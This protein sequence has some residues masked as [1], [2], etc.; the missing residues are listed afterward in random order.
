M[1]NTYRVVLSIAFALL[2]CFKTVAQQ[3]PD[4]Y[5][6]YQSPDFESPDGG[7]ALELDDGCIL[8]SVFEYDFEWA[9]YEDER[10]AAAKI[11]KLSPAGILLG[12]L[13][14]GYEGRRST[15]AGIYRDP[16]DEN[17]CVA[18]GKIH[19]NTMH[20][21]LPLIVKFDHDLNIVNQKEIELP[22]EYRCFFYRSRSVMDSQGDIVYL[23]IPYQWN[24][25]NPIFRHRTYMR[26]SSDGDLLALSED[27]GQA[28]N[29]R[30][31]IGSLFVFHDNSGDYGHAVP[32]YDNNTNMVLRLNRDLEIIAHQSI[33]YRIPTS[34]DPEYD[35]YLW[36]IGLSTALSQ[37]DSSLVIICEAQECFMLPELESDVVL[38]RIDRDGNLENVLINGFTNDSVEAPSS[39]RGVDRTDDALYFCNGNYKVDSYNSYIVGASGITVTKT[40]SSLDLIWQRFFQFNKK[41]RPLCVTAT[42]NG[43]LITGCVTD[44]DGNMDSYSMFAFQVL[45][46]GTVS[47]PEA[48]AYVRPYLFYPN[49]AQN[50][51]HLQYSPDVKPI[52]IELYDLQGRLVRTQSDGLESINL[53]GLG[54][55]Q[56]LMKVML[57]DG[58]VFTDTVLKE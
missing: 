19:D 44:S 21:D 42:T 18:I 11:L 24:D 3:Y 15:I 41:Y 46:D 8:V 47:I 28:G 17:R 39:L 53:Q 16:N 7:V 22:E 20:I 38:M 55:G 5:F 54:A 1:R 40:N 29:N 25:G 27:E 9:A 52:Q 30:L 6:T 50:E 49:P 37:P 23:T 48:E 36:E 4:F 14:F 33:P 31:D 32:L 13:T 57:E 26:I 58:K 35:L 2:A 56:Y 43:C 12:E 34:S 10:T 45:S 51:L